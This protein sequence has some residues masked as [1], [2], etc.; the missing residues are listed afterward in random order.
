[1]KKISLIIIG[2]I[3][4]IIVADV[5]HFYTFIYPLFNDLPRSIL[6]VMH[7]E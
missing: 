5:I 4:T 6:D 7:D 1:M 2:V 3:A